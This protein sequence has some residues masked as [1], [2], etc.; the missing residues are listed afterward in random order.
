MESLLSYL[1]KC[2]I[3]DL[4][5][6]DFQYNG[7]VQQPYSSHNSNSDS[8]S[9]DESDDFDPNQQEAAVKDYDSIKYTGESS[10]GSKL[11]DSNIFKGQSSIP[12]PGRDNIVLKLMSQDELMIVRTEKSSLTGKSDMLLDVGL[13]MRAPLSNE[14][15][16]TMSSLSSSS[17]S[18]NQRNM[19]KPAK[20]QIDKMIGM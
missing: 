16:N 13:S 7:C 4:E 6:N 14:Q 19:K 18:S 10:I 9:E 1:T 20:Y 2:S 3:K 8:S 17:L 11:F 15:H 5:R 12:W